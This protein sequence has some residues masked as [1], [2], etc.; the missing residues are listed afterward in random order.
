M[1]FGISAQ[2]LT[3]ACVK[4]NSNEVV[5]STPDFFKDITLHFAVGVAL[6]QNS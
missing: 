4:K 6:T 5:M 2:C 3:I 1:L